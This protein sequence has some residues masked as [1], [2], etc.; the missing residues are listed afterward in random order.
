MTQDERIRKNLIRGPRPVPYLDPRLYSSQE[1]YAADV[2]RYKEILEE[3]QRA[4][5][6]LS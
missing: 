2:V 5:R 6:A 1:E 3:Q 4:K